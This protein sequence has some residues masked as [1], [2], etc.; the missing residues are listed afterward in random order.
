VFHPGLALDPDRF[1]TVI[2]VLATMWLAF[3]IWV[4]IDPPGHS[5]FVVLTAS[6]GLGMA[7]SPQFRVSTVFLPVTLSCLFAGCL[8][9]LVM[10]HLVRMTV[11]A[12]HRRLLLLA[13]LLGGMALLWSDVLARGLLPGGEEL[14]VGVVTALMGGPFFCFLLKRRK[15]GAGL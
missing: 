2:R 1:A 8:Y 15:V 10:P 11:G 12:E 4:Y 13:G 6:M 3:L 5:G 9:L 14:P 7:R